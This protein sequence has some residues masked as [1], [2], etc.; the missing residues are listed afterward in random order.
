MGGW[1]ACLLHL[2]HPSTNSPSFRPSSVCTFSVHFFAT[3]S[4]FHPLFSQYLEPATQTG[5][6]PHEVLPPV[7]LVFDK[8]EEG[9]GA[10]MDEEGAMSR[11]ALRRL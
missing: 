5:P 1:V 3:R 10:W 4:V 11:P 9:D 6:S 8:V 7:V 2:T